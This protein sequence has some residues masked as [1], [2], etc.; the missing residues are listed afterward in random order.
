MT[1]TLHDVEQ[2]SDA[3]YSIRRGMP[4]G[5]EFH[6][7]VTSK[8]EE[9]KS[10]YDYALTLAGEIYAGKRLDGFEG[11]LYTERGKVLEPEAIA[12][13]SF[14]T[15][16]VVDKVG[17]VTLDDGTC[18]ASPDG[19][20][21]DD[22]VVEIKCLKCENHIKA[23]LYHRKNGVCPTDYVQQTQGELMV[24]GRKWNDLVFYHPNLPMLVIRQYPIQEVLD[25]LKSG[26][27]KLIEERDRVV[28]ILREQG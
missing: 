20:V 12:A 28:K 22:G 21:G 14:L 19:L 26:I 13:Y 15:D 2:G 6:R 7:I 27:S 8:G 17:F 10:L 9:S 3:W 11:N 5:S 4:T 23:I 24:T 16:S 25:G 1:S 18:G